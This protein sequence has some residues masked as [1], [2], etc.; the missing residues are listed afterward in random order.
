MWGK[1]VEF[2]DDVIEQCQKDIAAEHMMKLTHHS[3]YL[4]A[5]CKVDCD[6]QKG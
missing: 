2:A 1:V 4:Y 6:N 3:L 5:E